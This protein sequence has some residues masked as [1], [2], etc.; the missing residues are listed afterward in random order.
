MK[1]LKKSSSFRD[2]PRAG[3]GSYEHRP[4][5][6]PLRP[7]FVGSGLAGEAAPRSDPPS[8]ELFSYQMRTIFGVLS[9]SHLASPIARRVPRGGGI[10]LFNGG[11]RLVDQ[12]AKSVTVLAAGR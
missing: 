6:N 12:I 10:R 3:R 11:Q 2:G 4:S 9:A 8:G 1:T 5:P 7:V